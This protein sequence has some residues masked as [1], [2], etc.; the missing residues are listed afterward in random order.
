MSIDRQ[1]V[2]QQWLER[3]LTEHG[4][5]AGTVHRR[6]DGLLEIVGAVNI[7]PRVQEVTARIPIG[8]GMAG[9]AW[10]RNAP[11]S[12]CDLQQPSPDVK[13]GAAAVGAHAAAALPVRDHN[14][15]VRAIVGI[16]FATARDLT[17]PLLASL[18]DAA[19]CLP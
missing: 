2:H 15:H 4:G 3:F 1:S 12:T 9:L 5:A 10:Q 14:G 17:E 13:P 8:K 11:V 18:T 6:V 19:Q 7:P 16:A